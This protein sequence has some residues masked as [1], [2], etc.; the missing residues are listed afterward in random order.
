[1][2]KN[3]DEFPQIFKRFDYNNNLKKYLRLIEGVNNH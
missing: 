1:M 2:S 3:D